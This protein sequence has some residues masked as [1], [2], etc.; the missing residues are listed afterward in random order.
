VVASA[1]S[2]LTGYAATA[3]QPQAVPVGRPFIPPGQLGGPF[4]G[5]SVVSAEDVLARSGVA[6]VANERSKVPLV[7]VVGPVKERFGS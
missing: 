4:T 3:P 2:S 6:T 5:A 7:A 1:L